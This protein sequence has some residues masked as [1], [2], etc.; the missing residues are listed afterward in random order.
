MQEN[1]AEMFELIEQSK[2]LLPLVTGENRKKV[3]RTIDTLEGSLTSNISMREIHEER[4]RECI[5][6]TKILCEQYIRPSQFNDVHFNNIRSQADTLRDLCFSVLN[7]S[8]D[9]DILKCNHRIKEENLNLKDI[10]VR[11]TMIQISHE[12]GTFNISPNTG[13]QSDRTNGMEMWRVP[14]HN[15]FIDANEV[16]TLKVSLAG[17]PYGMLSGRVFLDPNEPRAFQ[18]EITLDFDGKLQ[19]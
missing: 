3:I 4:L 13:H 8:S 7:R 16:H 11:S 9:F 15:R 10:H 1:E 12:G 5:A 14:V 2:A 17:I 19:G 18:F 6:Q